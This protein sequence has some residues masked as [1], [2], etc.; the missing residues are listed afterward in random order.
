MKLFVAQYIELL[1]VLAVTVENE[2]VIPKDG[3]L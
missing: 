1:Q 2:K 3:D